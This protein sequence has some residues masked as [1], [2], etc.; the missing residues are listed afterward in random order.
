MGARHESSRNLSRSAFSRISVALLF[1]ACLPGASALADGFI[2]V[3]DWIP[4]VRRVPRPPHLPRPHFPL[5]VTRHRVTVEIDENFARTRVEETFHNRNNRQLEGTYIFPLP[6][7]ASIT[8]FTM[9]IGGK[10][11]SGEV[12]ERDKA[13]RI[14]EDIVRRAKDPGLLEY[15]D[16]GLFKARVFPIPARG[17]VDVSIEYS[18][19][20]TRTQGLSAY[21]YP[22]DTGKYSAGP[23][24]NVVV[25]V[26]LR[27]ASSIRTVQCPSHKGVSITRKGEREV[28]VSFEAREL[29]ADK[30]F[31][32]SWNVSEDALAPFL[33][34]HK[35][36]DGKGTFVLSISPRPDRPDK[37]VPKDVVFVIDT[38]GSMSGPKLDQVKKALKYC[39]RNLNDGDRFNIFDFSTEAR[40]FRDSLV[41]VGEENRS[42]A[43]AYV[44]GF[45][46]RG[47]TNIEEGLRFALDELVNQ[48]RL[49]MV[50]FLTDGEPTIGPVKPEEILRSVKQANRNQRRVFV[51]G[52]G[53]DLNVKLLD[54]LARDTKGS[55]QYIG[56]DENI[57][58]PLSAFY[59]KIDS[60]VLTDLTLDVRSDDVTDIYPRALPDLFHGEQLEIFG[61]YSDHGRKTVVLKG[62]LQGETRVFEYSL[63]FDGGDNDFIP[64]LWASR[65]I[66]YLLEQMRLSGESKEVKD[67]VI[68]LSKLFGILTPYT[69]YLIVEEDRRLSRRGLSAAPAAA[70]RDRGRG[71]REDRKHLEELESTLSRAKRSFGL[72]GGSEAVRLSQQLGAFKAGR[73]AESV[74]LFYMQVNAREERVKKIGPWT[75]Y[76]QGTRWIDSALTDRD[77]TKQSNLRRVKYLSDEYFALLRENPKI[78]R[79]LSVGPSVTFL[80]AGGVI[81]VDATD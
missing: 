53:E 63:A 44:D 31:I 22:L 41:S 8:N 68:R 48:D 51:F 78:G 2:Y 5:E 10:E 73:A 3:S 24:K 75:F 34:T 52:V 6:V 50:V 26:R 70:F 32:V 66:G 15:V 29:R 20:L 12:L 76:L 80:W 72:D 54:S 45:K 13:R 30:D 77:L 7:G 43:I 55:T 59:D 79:I 67:E 11:V 17:D 81:S 25:D 37:V 74:D 28:R 62:K 27:S 40:R 33:L 46:A 69:S 61:R 9:K 65:K 1:F 39:V 21:R 71:G 19:T 23:Y 58:V 18:E 47:G 4:H 38:S 56:S 42:A 60:P 64:R 16:R 35:G 14:Y 36:R 57:E 49:Q